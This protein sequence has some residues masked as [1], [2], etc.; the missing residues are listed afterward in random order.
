MIS[1]EKFGFKSARDSHYSPPKQRAHHQ[2]S[3]SVGLIYDPNTGSLRYPKPGTYSQHLKREKL[4]GNVAFPIQAAGKGILTSGKDRDILIVDGGHYDHQVSDDSH[5]SP[6]CVISNCILE[7]STSTSPAGSKAVSEMDDYSDVKQLITHN[8]SSSPSDADDEAFFGPL[9]GQKNIAP[10]GFRSLDGPHGGNLDNLLRPKNAKANGELGQ[11]IYQVTGM[12][13]R[14]ISTSAVPGLDSPSFQSK[15]GLLEALEREPMHLNGKPSTIAKPNPTSSDGPLIDTTSLGG[16]PPMKSMKARGAQSLSGSREL[17]GMKEN[18]WTSELEAAHQQGAAAKNSP[19]DPI[20]ESLMKASMSKDGQMI[21]FKQQ[22]QVGEKIEEIKRRNGMNPSGKTS[23]QNNSFS[24]GGTGA[25]SFNQTHVVRVADADFLDYDSNYDSVSNSSFDFNRGDMKGVHRTVLSSFQKPAP[26]KWDD[27]EKWLS[28]EP[29]A[30][31]KAKSGP[32]SNPLA[33]TEL[34]LSKKAAFLNQAGRLIPNIS[35]LARVAT[36]SNAG[37][38]SSDASS[39]GDVGGHN[40]GEELMSDRSKHERTKKMDTMKFI[41]GQEDAGN[42]RDSGDAKEGSTSP[43]APLLDLDPALRTEKPTSDSPPKEESPPK[44]EIAKPEQ[45]LPV[46]EPSPKVCMRDMGT[47]MT[48]IASVEPSRA[49]TPVSARTP[50]MRSP[51]S[52]RPATP[53]RVVPTSSPSCEGKD[54]EKERK[55]YYTDKELQSKTRQEILALGTQLGKHNIAAWATKEEEEE[56]A[57][58]SLKSS[59]DLEEVRKNVIATRAAAW[60]E[61]EQAKYVAR[62]KREEAKIQ[63]WENHEKAKAEAEMRRIEMKI[64]RMRSH[65]NEK[66]MNKVAATRRHAE[67]LRAAASARR[68]EQASKTAQ[69]AEYIRR[70]GKVPGSMFANLC[71]S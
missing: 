35:Q 27:A 59:V 1:Q 64:E 67:E 23:V 41:S 34:A 47:E 40:D 30:K 3:A 50:T 43:D 69:R 49:P 31:A 20:L 56:D 11:K 12:H 66:L 53:S 70:T 19:L 58:K 39:S 61:A 38:S 5:S 51:S 32:Q 57:F 15:A 26:S 71:C 7:S 36:V 22:N 29:P 42:N 2:T 24:H 63:A 54:G 16:G 48:P 44:V 6:R 45:P 18:G 14:S 9:N 52:S 37:T 21:P 25:F 28:S 17:L 46:S 68:G 33:Q 13:T 62:Y 10:S 8:R 4:A 65:A 60:E 55:V